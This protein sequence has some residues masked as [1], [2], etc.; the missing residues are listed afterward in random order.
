MKYVYSILVVLI[1]ALAV[2]TLGPSLISAGDHSLALTYPVSQMIAMRGVVALV[3]GVLAIVILIIA[4]IRFV[5]LRR[6][7]FLAILGVGLI[8]VAGGH[9]LI[10]NDRGL[11]TPSALP[12][13]YGV[14]HV[15]QGNGDVTVLS[16]NTLGSETSMSDLEPLVV[17]NGVDIVVL[18]ETSEESAQQLAESL[19]GRGL[20]FTVYSS[21]ADPYNP[22]IESTSVLVASSLGEYR[23]GPSLDLTWGSVSLRALGDGPDI[24]A[25]HPVAPV[26]DL[27]DAWREEITEVYGMCSSMDDAIMAG[28]FNSTVDHMHGTGAS[29]TSA[30]DGTIGGYGTWP[31]SF[32]GLL[33]SPIDNVF[34]DL[35]PTATAIVD[36]G[37]SDHRGILV[38]LAR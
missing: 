12:P 11:D 38:R 25:V 35:D 17:D 36:V 16:Y 4:V 8:A 14:T 31:T 2:A 20:S 22:E 29:C 21:G 34:T 5:M 9:Y 15:S 13:D 37:D 33:G 3:L 26:Q 28:D 7:L 27:Q 23:Q 1:L 10:L 24:I 6:G 18:S 19:S 30:L 32:T